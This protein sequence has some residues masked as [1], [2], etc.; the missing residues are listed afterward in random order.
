MLKRIEKLTPAEEALL[1][2]AETLLEATP[3]RRR[4]A[5]TLR[6]RGLPSRKV[7]AWHYTD[8]RTRLKEFAGLADTADDG[9]AW[10][11]ADRG[12]VEAARL[13]VINGRLRASLADDM[14]QGVTL[15]SFEGEGGFADAADAVAMLNTLIG[16]GGVDMGVAAGARVEKPVELLHGTISAGASAIRHKVAMGEGASATIVERHES[17]DGLAVQSNAVVDLEIADDARLLWVIVQTEGDAATH[18]AQLNVNL[19]ARAKLTVLVL[20]AGGALVRR[21]INVDVTG[22]D[23]DLQIRG[24]NLI[25]GETHLDVTTVLLHD[26]PGSV[27]TELFRNVATAHGAGIFQGQIRVA[28]I[29][30]KTDARMACNTL[31]LSDEAEFS[32][33]PELE[34]FAD[35]VQCAHGATVADIEDD[36]LFY[37]MA[38]G[39]PQKQA[40]AM[41][42]QA[43][44][45]E[46]FEEVE[47]EA[48]RDALNARIEN[49]LDRHG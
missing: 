46:A 4:A 35:D 32:A 29:A 9:Q 15:K 23:A 14:P 37:L 20:N 25:G 45:E 8:L 16:R 3:Q 34:I 28:Q 11:E 44:V 30:Q 33:K 5:E 6:E 40:R 26:V 43:F 41:L 39:I 38:R 2:A 10:I 18:L 27:S 24:V 13:P 48:L 1:S 21:E 42:V 49:W 12:L 19:G 36:H 22:E 31:L 47:D 17:A 7:E